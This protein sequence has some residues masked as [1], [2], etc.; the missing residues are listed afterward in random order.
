[1]TEP[2]PRVRSFGVS[3][4]FCSG[5]S[6]YPVCEEPNSM[7]GEQVSLALGKNRQPEVSRSSPG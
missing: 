3:L 2:P 6:E 1:M 7:R 4:S 5:R